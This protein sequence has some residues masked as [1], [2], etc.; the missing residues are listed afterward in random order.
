[1]TSR[2]IDRRDDAV[3]MIVDVLRSLLPAASDRVARR[4]QRVQLGSLIGMTSSEIEH[5]ETDMAAAGR[6]A[7]ARSIGA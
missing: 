7:P 4:M 5:L 2:D 6:P 3:D 1:M